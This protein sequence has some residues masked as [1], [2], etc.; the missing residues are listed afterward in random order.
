MRERPWHGRE[1]L[2][3]ISSVKRKAATCA[4]TVDV[5][6]K[7]AIAAIISE[8]STDRRVA[9]L[10]FHVGLGAKLATLNWTNRKIKRPFRSEFKKN[11]R[12]GRRVDLK[13]K[14]ASFA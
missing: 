13:I 8:K 14:Y 11:S 5:S 4:A 1:G 6:V 2:G 7:M 12:P 10:S 3:V 9:G